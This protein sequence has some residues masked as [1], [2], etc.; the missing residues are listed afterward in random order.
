MVARG[1][2]SLYSQMVSCYIGIMLPFRVVLLLAQVAVALLAP[3]PSFALGRDLTPVRMATPD[4]IGQSYAACAT[5]KGFLLRW[6]SPTR[7]YGTTADAA[8]VPRMPASSISPSSGKLFPNGDG[9]LALSQDGIA[10]LDAGGAVRRSVIFDQP[11]PLFFSSA[12][13][14]GTNFLLL[15]GFVGGGYTGRLVDRNGHVLYTAKLP[16]PDSG[17]SGSVSDVT[18]SPDGGFTVVVA[19]PNVG[20]FAVQI[21]ATG[22]V[23]GTI[24]FSL[25]GDQKRFLVSVATNAGQTVVAW[26]TLGSAYMHTV[27][28]RGGSIVRDAILPATNQLSQNIALLPSGDGFILLQNAY[29]APPANHYFVLTT[30][31]DFSGA[32]REATATLLNGTFSAAAATSRT[33]VLLS[34]P[35]QVNGSLTEVSAAIDNSGIGSAATYNIVATAVQQLDPAV[36]SDGVDFFG[37]WLETTSTTISVMAGRVTRSGLPLDGTGLVVAESSSTSFNHPLAN[38]SVA[39][40]AGVYLVV[41]EAILPFPNHSVMGRR[42]ARDGTPIDPA[43]FLITP[44]GG[45]PSVAFGGGRFLVAWQFTDWVSL[46]GA[47]VASDG[48]VGVLQMLTPPPPQLQ[49]ELGNVGRPMIGWNGRHF[50]VAYG[51]TDPHSYAPR[52]RMLRTSTLGIPLDAHTTEAVSGGGDATIACSDQE[53]L[54]GSVRDA[55][56]VSAIVHDDAALHAD[57]PK[58]IANSRRASYAAVAFDGAWYI[59]AW[60]TGDSLLGVARISRGGEPYALAVAGTVNANVTYPASPPAL[61]TDSAGDTAIVTSEVSTVWLID[62]A[63]FYFASELLTPRRRAASF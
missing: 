29:T 32:P 22:Q 60:R 39:F 34:Y 49:E 18:V 48:S 55:D 14:D 16:V 13:F 11:A 23:T 51:L 53:C 5:E 52:V 45:G 35:D 8:G 15:S 28:L 6:S 54:V 30:R 41:Y 33:L 26:T 9:Y 59:L 17:I 43:P 3:L 40:G 25:A 2:A 50:I 46:A 62:R 27:A 31:L 61:A 12:A 24:V 44:N 57:T 38:P 7:A 42:F 47:P 36:A 19:G 1:L 63:R 4:Y 10:E 37:A 20:V 58:I 21:S 56:I